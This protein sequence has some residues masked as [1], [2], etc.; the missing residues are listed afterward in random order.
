MYS[1]AQQT[2]YELIGASETSGKA[3][4]GGKFDAAVDLT[5]GQEADYV[6]HGVGGSVYIGLAHDGAP[7]AYWQVNFTR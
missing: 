2:A 3:V 5:L 4:C 1:K 6:A 7:H